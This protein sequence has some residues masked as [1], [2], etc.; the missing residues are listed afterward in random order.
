MKN[1]E[2]HEGW[3]NI[4]VISVSETLLFHGEIDPTYYCIGLADLLKS[5]QFFNSAAADV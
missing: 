1:R 5:S 4:V 2:W 3:Q